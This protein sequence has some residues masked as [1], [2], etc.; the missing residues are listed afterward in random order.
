M[1]IL[2]VGSKRLKV[3]CFLLGVSNDSNY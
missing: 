2:I 3:F 1:L